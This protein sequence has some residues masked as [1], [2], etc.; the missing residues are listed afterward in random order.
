MKRRGRETRSMGGWARGR[1]QGPYMPP[2][3]QHHNGTPSRAMR[4]PPTTTRTAAATTFPLGVSAS[5]P[6]GTGLPKKKEI[7]NTSPSCCHRT[8]DFPGPTRWVRRPREVVIDH[9]DVQRPGGAV[10][11]EAVIAPA[12]TQNVPQLLV[13]DQRVHHLGRRL[14]RPP[15]VSGDDAIRPEEI[16]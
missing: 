9:H 15:V 16:E 3:Y 12:V 6:S 13:L 11:W 5:A 7:R 8:C 14:V 10:G 4:T 2:S 1:R